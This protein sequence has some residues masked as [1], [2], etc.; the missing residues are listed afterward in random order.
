MKK[1]LG[2][3]TSSFRKLREKDLVYVDKTKWIYKLITEG[4]CYFLSKPRRFGKSLTISTL[5]ELFY[6]NKELFKG[7]YIYDKWDFK[8]HP[9]LIF[10]FNEI[11]NQTPSIF[12]KNKGIKTI[13]CGINFDTEKREV[14]E[15]VFEEI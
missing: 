8:K 9:V 5:K 13:L 7:V 4:E 15:I 3:D 12:W 6:G 2:P 11:D 14:K 1:R 10:D